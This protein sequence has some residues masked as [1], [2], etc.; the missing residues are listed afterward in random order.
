MDDSADVLDQYTVTP[1]WVLE[2]TQDD[3]AAQLIPKGTYDGQITTF[4]TRTNDKVGSPFYGH[5]VVRLTAELFNVEGR[6]RPYFFS[7]SPY[8]AQMSDGRDYEESRNFRKLAEATGTVGKRASEVLTAASQIRLTF[9]LKASPAKGEYGP[10][11]WTD[12][13][14]AAAS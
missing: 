6:T 3:Q 1:E 13:I 11:N 9:K 7:A 12:N 5:P 8:R 2:G 10:R 14:T 4:V